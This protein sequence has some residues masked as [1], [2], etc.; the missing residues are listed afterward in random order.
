MDIPREA[1]RKFVIGGG[2]TAGRIDGL[3]RGIG[4]GWSMSH[5]R[6]LAMRV[7]ATTPSEV[8][9]RNTG[10]A[11]S[12]LRALVVA[13]IGDN[14]MRMQHARYRGFNAWRGG[15]R[16]FVT[17]SAAVSDRRHARR[18]FLTGNRRSR[19]PAS[20]DVRQVRVQNCCSVIGLSP[21][22]P[23]P[24]GSISRAC[25]LPLEPSLTNSSIQVDRL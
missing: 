11:L 8:R 3:L 17:E 13:N 9:C 21:Q 2:R 19:H 25:A 15:S 4:C 1:P 5:L 22:G 16:F 12:L 6:W 18:N 24:F 14:V 10:C 7:N 23:S 20:A